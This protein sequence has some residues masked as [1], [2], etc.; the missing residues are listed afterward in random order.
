M[1]TTILKTVLPFVAIAMA[2]FGAFAFNNVPE[3]EAALL[4]YGAVFISPGHCEIS[5]VECTEIDTGNFCS[6][7][8]EWL[9]KMEASGTACP[10][11]LYRIN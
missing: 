8:S 5:S 9:Y 1:K 10:D 7:G 4:P 2:I 11:P 3:K 6:N